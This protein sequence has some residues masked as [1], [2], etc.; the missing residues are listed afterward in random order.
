MHPLF[1]YE[2]LADER[3][4]EIERKLRFAHFRRQEELAEASPPEPVTLRMRSA[5]D[6]D[7]LLNLALLSA[8]RKPSGWYVVAEVEGAPVA[9]LPLAGGSALTDPF[10][11]TAHLL[12]LLE[13]RVAQ[14][15]GERPRRRSLA[16]R[17][18]VPR[19]SRA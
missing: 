6:D 13:L 10:R 4:R 5:E 18:A 11:R 8:S 3:R 19:W 9:A 7:Q 17:L 1:T 12:P 14:I 15:T 16:A 2:F